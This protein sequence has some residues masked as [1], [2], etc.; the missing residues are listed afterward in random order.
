VNN[1]LAG[2]TDELVKMA[3]SIG[4][5]SGIRTSARET[6]VYKD[7]ATARVRRADE[8]LRNAQWNLGRA[9][10]KLDTEEKSLRKTM[11]FIQSNYGPKPVNPAR[12]SPMLLAKTS[13]SRKN[14]FSRIQNQA[15]NTRYARGN[16]SDYMGT[17]DVRNQPW[18]SMQQVS[19]D[20]P[21]SERAMVEYKPPKPPK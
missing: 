19:S 8:N 11:D 5:V 14:P 3:G 17:E 12:N 7:P 4:D 13:A 9:T 20:A 2:F 21:K 10:R 16:M 15:D 1:F 18:P 6:P